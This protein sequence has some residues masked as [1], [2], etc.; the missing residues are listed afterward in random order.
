MVPMGD[1]R[2]AAKWWSKLA[3]IPASARKEALV[4]FSRGS[5]GRHRMAP[6]LTGIVG[7]RPTVYP[8]IRL[9]S[10]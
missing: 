5:P 6:G 4:L 7:G 2:T 9:F 1:G 8:V 3:E 10:F